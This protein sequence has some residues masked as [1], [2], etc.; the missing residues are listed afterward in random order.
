MLTNINFRYNSRKIK[1]GDRFYNSLGNVEG[2]L[3]Y[4]QLKDSPVPEFIAD[5]NLV[6]KT[7]L[8]PRKIKTLAES[9]EPFV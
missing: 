3:T 5:I 2:R 8:P 6:A 7:P 4:K 9:Q 1:D